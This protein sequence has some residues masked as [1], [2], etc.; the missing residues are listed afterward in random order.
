M[1]FG[2]EVL[3]RE[4]KQRFA[5]NRNPVFDV[6]ILDPCKDLRTCLSGAISFASKK[7]IQLPSYSHI[8]SGV[9]S[10]TFRIGTLV[11]VS[12]STVARFEEGILRM[13]VV[14]GELSELEEAD[15]HMRRWWGWGDR[16]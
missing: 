12:Q 6:V 14:I 10:P 1:K 15:V 4:S 7:F 8:M 9:I 5:F 13:R 3:K 16:R 11:G 2:H